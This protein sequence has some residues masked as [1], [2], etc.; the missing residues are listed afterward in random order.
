M[1]ILP[2][3]GYL[4]G[5]NSVPPQNHVHQEPVDVKSFGNRVIVDIS[6]DE[7]NWY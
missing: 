4:T 6:Q 1:L 3:F 2:T 5:L 7:I